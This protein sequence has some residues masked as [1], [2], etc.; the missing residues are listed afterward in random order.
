MAHTSS[1]TFV[2]YVRTTCGPR[3]VIV[4]GN[5]PPT[6]LPGRKKAVRGA[7]TRAPPAEA[8]PPAGT[9]GTSL[10]A[11]FLAAFKNFAAFSA[12]VRK[13]AVALCTSQTGRRG[14][15]MEVPCAGQYKCAS[16][17][18]WIAVS[19][20]S[21]LAGS[22]EPGSNTRSARH[23][24]KGNC[25]KVLDALPSGLLGAGRVTTK[26]PGAT[27]LWQNASADRG[28]AEVPTDSSTSAARAMSN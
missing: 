21:V 17:V 9:A 8:W 28:T 4:S 14:L 7:C 20:C 15:D 22:A 5:P 27:G 13:K 12:G 26:H 1:T 10:A 19:K 6:R 18:G 3:E 24:Q 25:C 16:K 2:T 11:P 23:T